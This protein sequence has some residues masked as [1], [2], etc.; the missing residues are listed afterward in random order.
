MTVNDYL[1]FIVDEIHSTVVATVDGD[2]LPVTCVIDMMYADENGLYFLTAKG[3]NFYQRLKDKG[4]LSLSGKKGED[5]MSCT[6]VSVRGKVRELGSAMLPLLFE[7]N[8]YM[9]EIYPTEES[10]KALTAFQLYEGSGEWFDLSKKPIE[11]DSFTFGGAESKESGYFVTD[12]CIGCGSCL[13][14]CPQSCIE[15]KEKAIIRQE[16]CLHCGNCAEVCP[17]GA[18]IRR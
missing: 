3:K 9:R 10:R 17:V 1:R 6:A 13:S 8:P 11:R 14:D 4:Y 7:K 15:L 18:V 2:G 5:T 12:D 16:N